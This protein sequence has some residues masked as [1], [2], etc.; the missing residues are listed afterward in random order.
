MKNISRRAAVQSLAFLPALTASALQESSPAEQIRDVW[1]GVYS[2]EDSGIP[3]FPNRFLAEIVQG[4]KPGPGSRRRYGA[5]EEFAFPGAAGLGRDRGRHFRQGHR[6]RPQRS[7][8]VG[9]EDQL[10]GG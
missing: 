6:P 3:T 2:K 9:A 4:R 7:Y 5:G 1:N 8:P 10:R